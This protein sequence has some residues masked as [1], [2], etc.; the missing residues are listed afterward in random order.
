MIVVSD[1]SPLTALLT[2]GEIS[3]L[4][5]LFSEVVIPEA[6][7][8]ELCRTHS[9]LPD[10]IRVHVVRNRSSA[11]HFA[12]FVDLGEAEAIAL[13]KELR[14]DHLLIDERKGR[15]LAAQE[16]LSVI[17]LLGAVILA[18][19]RGLIPSART[20]LERLDREAGVYLSHD[21]R[22]SALKTVNE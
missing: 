12:Q 11:A 22:E 6:V 5:E 9:D 7:Q 19:K 17:G 8:M 4:R 2:V 10:W 1:T 14:A 18:R 3:I 16:G 13:A 21:V 15:R 20:L